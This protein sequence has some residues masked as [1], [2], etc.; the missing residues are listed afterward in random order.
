MFALAAPDRQSDKATMGVFVVSG[1]SNIV[2]LVLDLPYDEE[3]NVLEIGAS[4]AKSVNLHFY[5]TTVSI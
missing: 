5:P 3:G 4:D 2:Q 1:T